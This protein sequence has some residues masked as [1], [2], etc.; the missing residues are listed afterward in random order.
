MIDF[1]FSP[2]LDTLR[3]TQFLVQIS[4]TMMA[5]MTPMTSSLM[6]L[7]M[8]ELTMTDMLA[9]VQLTMI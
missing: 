7:T 4:D 5:M 2:L 8:T 9:R 1:V 6:I 3:Y